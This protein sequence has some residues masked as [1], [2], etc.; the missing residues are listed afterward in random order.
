MMVRTE[1]SGTEKCAEGSVGVHQTSRGR[2]PTLIIGRQ[3]GRRVSGP[4]TQDG[5]GPEV[6]P[7]VR[8]GTLF[9]HP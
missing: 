6:P 8:V 7:W 1:G 5:K 9:L 2:V 3:T 4:R